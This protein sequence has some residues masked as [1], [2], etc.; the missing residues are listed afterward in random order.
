[1]ASASAP[2]SLDEAQQLVAKK[3][4][5]SSLFAELLVEHFVDDRAGAD[6]S[7]NAAGCEAFKRLKLSRPAPKY[8]SRAPVREEL[9]QID[10]LAAEGGSEEGTLPSD[11]RSAAELL[12]GD[13]FN[14]CMALKP[15]PLE[16]ATAKDPNFSSEL[17]DR[18]MGRV[19]QQARDRSLTAM[20]A[21]LDDMLAQ[22][23][24]ELAGSP[25]K[26]R[27]LLLMLAHPGLV[28]PSSSAFEVLK[29]LFRLVGQ[30]QAQ[31]DARDVLVQ[32]F[33]PM[34][35]AHL[36]RSVGTVQQFLTLSL[37]CAQ[38][39]VGNSSL[40]GVME[41]ARAGDLAKHVRNALRLLD[42]YWRANE[43]RREF[44]HD[45]RTRRRA[46]LARQRGERFDEE[47]E[48]C[49]PPT[50]FHNDAINE[51]EGLLKHDLKE[52]LERP[53]G[54]YFSSTEEERGDF[55]IIE[56]P[57]VL[58]P[59][60]KV[61]MLSIESI[62][63]Q[64]EEVRHAMTWQMV[65]RGRM[66]MNPFLV[67]KVR[68]GAVIEDALQQLAQI[69]SQQFKKQLK[70]VFDGEEGVDEG[71]VQKEF[72]QLLIEEL[73]NE[74]FGMFE[75]VDETR[76]FWF[77]KNSFEANLQFELFGIVIGLAIYNQ[78]ILD[79]KFP[80]AMYTSICRPRNV[81]INLTLSDLLDFQP[82]L[83]QGLIAL[84]EHEPG[85]SFE[86]VFGP[87]HF[88][89]EY[90]CF[91]T[92]VEAELK[93]GGKDVPVTAENRE[94]YVQKYCDWIFSTSVERQYGAFRRGFDKCIGD[95]LFRQLFRP[96]ELELVICGSMELD[97]NALEQVT[98]YQ[99]G[100][101]KGSDAVRWLWETVHSLSQEE[102]RTFLA[103]CT[104]CD[105]APVGGLGRLPFIVSRAGPD[106]DM[107]PWVHTCFNHFL[108]PDYSSKEKLEQRLRLAI[109]HS[110]GFGLM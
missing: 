67:L 101:N 74:D 40:E 103:F 44:R 48:R 36:E 90:D 47:M 100:Y 106:S 42:L 108:L 13:F 51:W 21:L 27:A 64:R 98:T 72:F 5:L 57:F 69:S 61:R 32:W 109:Q 80:M 30:L 38:A 93:A 23:S 46:Q 55:G 107:L 26:L 39:E 102:K 15:R 78:V 110:T 71:G 52:A 11:S 84:L 37:L 1:M 50:S 19:S 92:K 16:L 83:A 73:Y 97:F 91:G 45:W 35:F 6:A 68:R 33:A 10:G 58:T 12:F 9:A 54:Q 24:D 20:G 79:I 87:L 29:K 4:H 41:I 34:P 60:S 3:K 99:D 63:M 2:A 31:P 104:G 76:N 8:F 14:L 75:K 88:V 62:L 77:N 18:L 96:D 28:D 89:V 56:F 81:D 65:L 22:G 94:E 86:D 70:V 25:A 95:T 59:V 49:L 85:S 105:R 17:L 53:R 7:W 66:P 82:S 43:R